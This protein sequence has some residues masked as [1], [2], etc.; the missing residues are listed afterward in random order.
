MFLKKGPNNGYYI[1]FH[2]FHIAIDENGLA[3]LF[4]ASHFSV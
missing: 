2:P 3:R 1:D 4:P